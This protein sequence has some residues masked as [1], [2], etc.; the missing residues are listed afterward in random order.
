MSITTRAV[1]VVPLQHDQQHYTSCVPPRMSNVRYFKSY[2]NGCKRYTQ[3]GSA[4]E[5]FLFYCTTLL[6]PTSRKRSLLLAPSLVPDIHKR[7]I[8]F[9]TQVAKR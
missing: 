6:C 1:H 9:V 2:A 5:H 7:A 8:Q 3:Q 4:D